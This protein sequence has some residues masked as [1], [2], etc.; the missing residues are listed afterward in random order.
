[1]AIPGNW[2][3]FGVGANGV[4]SVSKTLKIGTSG[5]PAP[6]TAKGATAAPLTVRFPQTP[7]NPDVKMPKGTQLD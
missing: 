7:A 2:M 4:P 1:V 5:G 3:V 6:A